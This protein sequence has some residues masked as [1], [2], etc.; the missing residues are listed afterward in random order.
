MKVTENNKE[1]KERQPIIQVYLDWYKSR[2]EM[3]VNNIR[4]FLIVTIVLLHCIFISNCIVHYYIADGAYKYDDDVYKQIEAAIEE[5]VPSE[6]GIGLDLLGLK[7][8]LKVIKMK[9]QN[10]NSFFNDVVLDTKYNSEDGKTI[11]ICGVN[12]GFFKPRITTELGP[13]H[14]FMKWERN[15]K[16]VQMYQNYFWKCY[17]MLTLGVGILYFI[18]LVI[19]YNLIVWFIAIV[20]RKTMEHLKKA[21]KCVPT[22]ITKEAPSSNLSI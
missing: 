8:K 16:S 2:K 14:S 10:E 9:Y 15:F 1:K 22:D 12:D 21:E 4:L 5:T 11:L 13:D 3:R 18:L 17:R 20:L 7:E 19:L 6:A